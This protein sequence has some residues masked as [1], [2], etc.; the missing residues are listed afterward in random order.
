MSVVLS[1]QVCGCLLLQPQESNA[2]RWSTT[3][4]TIPWLSYHGCAPDIRILQQIQASCEQQLTEQ[5][6]QVLCAPLLVM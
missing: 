3:P 5:S 2:G 1:Y 4:F 6:L